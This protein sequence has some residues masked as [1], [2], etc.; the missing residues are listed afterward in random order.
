MRLMTWPEVFLSMA[1]VCLAFLIPFVI[2]VVVITVKK[3]RP[4]PLVVSV[5]IGLTTFIGVLVL[6]PM[7]PRSRQYSWL[8]IV[9][10][11]LF[12]GLL[13]FVGPHVMLHLQSVFFRPYEESQL[14]ATN[15]QIGLRGNDDTKRVE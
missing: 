6:L 3:I 1:G 9:V 2:F 4:T 10:I 14:P 15:E 13:A 5:G 7:D 8:S 12:L 11:A